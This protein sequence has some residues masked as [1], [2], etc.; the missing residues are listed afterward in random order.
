MMDMDAAYANAD[1]IPD[2]TAYFARWAAQ[3]AAFRAAMGTRAELDLT[4]GSSQ[5][6]ALDLFH[7]DAPPKG[8][9]VFIH[10]G[11]WRESHRTDWSHL[12]AGPLARGWAV[13]MPSYDLCPQVSI[14]DITDQVE[15]AI[16]HAAARIPGPI[17]LTGHSAGGHLVARMVC[18]DRAP[19]WRDRLHRVVPISPVAELA[20]LMQT[21][22]NA[23]LAIDD[24]VAAT[25][26]P[27]R[28]S[29]VE[30]PVTVWVGA[31][32]RPAFLEQSGWL[33]AAWGCPRV[34]DPDRHHFD[35]IEGLERPDSPLMNAVLA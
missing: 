29:P 20:P 7:P 33:A 3:A 17:R 23:D 19:A 30:V 2:G 11:Y 26:S 12:A 32:E 25:Q 35:V 18:A 21:T 28:L 24:A 10:G 31:E 6:Q 14:A 9:L 1:F 8:L 27:A 16:A 22:M 34:V 4:Y 5:R 13:A 15:A